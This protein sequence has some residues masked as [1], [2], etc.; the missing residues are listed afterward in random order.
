MAE[1][2]QTKVKKS[3]KD[4]ASLQSIHQLNT[5]SKNLKEGLENDCCTL[6]KLLEVSVRVPDLNDLNSPHT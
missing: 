5:I 3:T 6:K 4:R 2:I 1:R